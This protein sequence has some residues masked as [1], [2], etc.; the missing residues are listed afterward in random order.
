MGRPFIV[1]EIVKKDIAKVKAYAEDHKIDL[2]ELRGIA[3]MDAPAPGLDTNFVCA[4]PVGYLVAFT[5]EQ[6]PGG[7]ARH[8]SVSS[9]K[10]GTVPHPTVVEMVMEEFG[11]QKKLSECTIYLE[12]IGRDHQ[13]VNVVEIYEPK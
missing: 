12:D 10:R 6:H 4:I 1:D 3:S 13:A 7:W 9:E 11:M 5:I 8:I 2:T